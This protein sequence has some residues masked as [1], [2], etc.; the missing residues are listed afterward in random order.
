MADH[1]LQQCRE[2]FF[3]LLNTNLAAIN[4]GIVGADLQIKGVYKGRRNTYEPGELPALNI[5]MID[6]QV[7]VET[8]DVKPLFVRIAS[9]VLHLHYVAIN[10]VEP[11]IF[12]VQKQI[13]ILIDADSTLTDACEQIV[14]SASEQ[15]EKDDDFSENPN[16]VREFTFEITMHTDS[17]A[18]DCLVT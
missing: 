16:E 18:P 14:L 7:E 6:E 9:L 11:A 3:Q 13:E 12:E 15:Q 4:A 5:A 10:D 17:G 1:Y 8:M 2:N